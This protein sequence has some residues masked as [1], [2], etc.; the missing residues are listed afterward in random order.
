M[1]SRQHILTL[2]FVSFKWCISYCRWHEYRCFLCVRGKW[3]RSM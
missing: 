3:D 2:R 1:V